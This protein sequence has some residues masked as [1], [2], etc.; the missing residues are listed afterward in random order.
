VLKGLGFGA[1]RTRGAAPW[2]RDGPDDFAGGR[3]HDAWRGAVTHAWQT[4]NPDL[5]MGGPS[6]DWQAAFVQLRDR[7]LADQA[8]IAPPT[9]ILEAERPS[10]CITLP[11]AE[12]RRIPGA[13]RAMELE[14]NRRRQPWLSAV[15]Q[16][17]AK[18]RRPAHGVAGGDHA[19]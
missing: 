2:R 5:R 8:R 16:F 4:A 7:T 11:G 17:L 6:L 10:A 14:D 13:A 9:L 1:V 3:T 12:R 15:E 18:T 19:P